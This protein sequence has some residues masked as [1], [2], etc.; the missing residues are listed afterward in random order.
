MPR[1]KEKPLPVAPVVADEN[2]EEAAAPPAEPPK[3]KKPT[4]DVRRSPHFSNACLLPSPSSPTGSTP[5]LPGRDR[6][7]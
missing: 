1:R 3:A 5:L 4:I 7:P 2:A 6:L